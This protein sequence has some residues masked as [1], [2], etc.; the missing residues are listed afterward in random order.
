MN[1]RVGKML[2]VEWV[3][4]ILTWQREYKGYI[5]ILTDYKQPRATTG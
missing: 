3:Y 5:C 4:V 2:A 1:G